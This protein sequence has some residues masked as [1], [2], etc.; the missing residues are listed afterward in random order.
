MQCLLCNGP[1]WPR[2]SG[3][4]PR[5]EH[6]KTV[7]DIVWCRACDFGR[8]DANLTPESV[9]K[10]YEIAYYTRD[11]GDT[12]IRWGQP[13]FSDRIR[14]HLAWR[15]D[16]GRPLVPTPSQGKSMCDVGCGA[17]DLM[18]RYAAAG[19]DVTGVDPDPGALAHKKFKSVHVGS[20]EQLPGQLDA[21]S[22]DV[23]VMSHSLEH[24]IDPVLA[25][26]NCA[27]I[28]KPGGQITIEV[29]NGSAF[30]L[31]MHGAIWPY[32]DVPRHL[33]FFTE[34]SLTR[35]MS[36]F[37]KVSDVSYVGF[38]R[39][40]YREWINRQAS[41][42]AANGINRTYEIDAWLRLARGVVSPRR[43]KYDSVRVTAIMSA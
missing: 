4:D 12:T 26:K 17:G 19:Y 11:G 1:M 34:R 15:I 42:A 20:A 27:R 38:N 30:G 39:Q 8:V 13:T 7:Y 43:K 2:F 40:F 3:R 16:R 41:N 35:L 29:P 25:V 32:A 5:R 33:S 22:F 9:S 23:V 6:D 36:R 37:A 18:D 28:T 24:C 31:N 10:L 21:R 14:T